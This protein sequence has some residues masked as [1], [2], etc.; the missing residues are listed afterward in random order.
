MRGIK[1]GITT[2]YACITPWLA[3]T[4]TVLT[5]LRFKVDIPVN[6]LA[7]MESLFNQYPQHQ[8]L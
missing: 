3:V 7:E 8:I 4:A 2:R 1:A 5:S 6:N